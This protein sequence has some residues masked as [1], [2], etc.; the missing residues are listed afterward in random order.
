MKK[1]WKSTCKSGYKFTELDEVIKRDRK[2]LNAN[3][4]L[5]RARDTT[6]EIQAILPTSWTI[7]YTIDVFA[8]L[9]IVYLNGESR[10]FYVRPWKL[11]S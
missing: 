5:F 6:N 10:L 11:F 3:E 2:G 7:L 4:Q 1:S 9:R 8:L